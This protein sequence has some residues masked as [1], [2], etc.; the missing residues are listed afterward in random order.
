VTIAL[1]QRGIRAVLLDIEG[2]T[3]PIAFVHDVLFPHARAHAHAFLD[4]H[5]ADDAVREATRRLIVEHAEDSTKTDSPPP[6][7]IRSDAASRASMARYVE[8]LIDRDRKAPGLKLLQG[9]I[10]EEGYR[11]GELHGEVYPD[12][13]PA[14]TNLHRAG[15]RIAIYSSGSALA[16]QRLFASTPDGDLTPLITRFFDTEIGAKREVASYARIC[17]TLQVSPSL[18]LFLSDVV[19]ELDAAAAAGLAVALTI[20]PGNPAQPDADRYEQIT[21]FDQITL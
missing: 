15:I 11:A 7:D 18:T 17:E 6:L 13:A 12:V 1:A 21:S 8:W 4:V 10:W 9:L 16:Q 19:P 2:T 3:T 14:L 5:H 20:R